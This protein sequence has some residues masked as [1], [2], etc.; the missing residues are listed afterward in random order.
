MRDAGDY[1]VVEIKDGRYVRGYKQRTYRKKVTTVMA[2]QLLA[3]CPKLYER[4]CK[5]V[6]TMSAPSRLYLTARRAVT[7]AANALLPQWILRSTRHKIE[8]FL[9]SGDR[10][11]LVDKLIT[12]EKHADVVYLFER[13]LEKGRHLELLY[14][15]GI[16]LN[17]KIFELLLQVLLQPNVWLVN[18]GELSLTD[19][20]FQ[21]LLT[22]LQESKVTH[23][24]VGRRYP[25]E[26][27]GI[28]T[29]SCVADGRKHPGRYV[30]PQDTFACFTPND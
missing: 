8:D 4:V 23:L 13:V 21:Q 22:V 20:Q 14:L 5:G 19:S 30:R 26:E 29:C 15:K 10:I 25:K 1:F 18:M 17:S 28:Y 16:V 6:A 27:F 11:M 3:A 24:N 12:K 9:A 7:R 2:L